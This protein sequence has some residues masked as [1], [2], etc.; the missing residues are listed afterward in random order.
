MLDAFI[1]P[2]R[3][4]EK[5]KKERSIGITMGVLVI[6]LVF[7]TVTMFLIGLKMRWWLYILFFVAQ[8]VALVIAALGLKITL[9]ILG[10]RFCEYYDALTALAYGIAPAA[11]AG[12]VAVGLM[13]IFAFNWVAALVA[14]GIAGLIGFFGLVAGVSAKYRVLM[15]LARVDLLTAVVGTFITWAGVMIGVYY[16]V[17]TYLLRLGLLVKPA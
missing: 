11:L 10:A 1:R 15:E 2:L 13:R 17:F 16:P 5:A 8:F 7:G 14:A 9:R 3:A 4:I 12:I 6:A